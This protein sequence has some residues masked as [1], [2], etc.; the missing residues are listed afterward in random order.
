MQDPLLLSGTVGLLLLVVK[1][2]NYTFHPFLISEADQDPIT[3]D[4]SWPVSSSFEHIHWG[5]LEDES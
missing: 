2:G 1:P 3:L 5:G 4:L